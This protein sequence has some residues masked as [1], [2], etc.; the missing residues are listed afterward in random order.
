MVDEALCSACGD[1]EYR[2]QMEA[3]GV[4]NGYAVVNNDRC[5]GCGL[6]VTTCP[7]M[8]VKLVRK[9]ETEQASVPRNTA[10]LYIEALQS[11]GLATKRDLV[12]WVVR[13]RVDRLLTRI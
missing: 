3:I 2:C 12:R 11:R 6:C 10:F 4:N 8:A 5:I 13:S 1:C 7:D 9:P